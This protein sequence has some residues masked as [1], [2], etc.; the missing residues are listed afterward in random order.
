MRLLRAY[1]WLVI[2]AMYL[3]I[4]VVVAAS[5]NSSKVPTVWK[6]FTLQ[7]YAKLASWHDAW[8]SLI[9]S[10]LVAAVVATA[11]IALGV[12]LAYAYRSGPPLALSLIPVV[13]PEIAES[14]AFALTFTL[15]SEV[16][17]NLFGPVGVVLAHLAFSIPM[18]HVLLSPYMSA[19][20]GEMVSAARVLGSS[21]LYAFRKI[22]IGYAKP[23]LLVAWLIIFASSFDTYIKTVFSTS[24][25]FKTAPIVL[26]NYVARGRG[27]PTLFALAAI[28]VIPALVAGLAYYYLVV[29]IGATRARGS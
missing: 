1:T 7:W 2:V 25:G 8:V 13:M 18:A 20:I 19:R 29:R 28:L 26:F 4:A 16:G 22:V 12:F 21:E 23:A 11:S 10:F 15:L 3:P 5:I 9:N 24:P 27:D 14:L 17:I 6:G